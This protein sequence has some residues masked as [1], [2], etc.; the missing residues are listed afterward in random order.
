MSWGVGVPVGS[1]GG[2][3]P[4]TMTVWVTARAPVAAKKGRKVVYFIISLV[5][6]CW[7]EWKMLKRPRCGG[8]Q[9]RSFVGSEK[10]RLDSEEGPMRVIITE[11]VNECVQSLGG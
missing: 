4:P 10:E 9:I 7:K 8:Y 11:V 1:V 5:E 6:M 3:T 2:L